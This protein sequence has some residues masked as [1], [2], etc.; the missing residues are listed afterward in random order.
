MVGYPPFAAIEIADVWINLRNWQKNLKRPAKNDRGMDW[1]I[2]DNAWSLITDLI[3]R[4]KDRIDSLDKVQKHPFF[5][6]FDLTNVL[7]VNPPFI[8]IIRYSYDTRNFDDFTNSD[9]MDLYRD[10]FERHKA[11]EDSQRQSLSSDIRCEF[12]NYEYNYDE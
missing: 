10:V 2:S 4:R 8:P 5:D 12:I 6:T 1:K 7:K 11:I 3:T 9:E